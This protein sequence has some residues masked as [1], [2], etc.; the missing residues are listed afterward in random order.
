M[1]CLALPDLPAVSRHHGHA[2]NL[3]LP[4][5]SAAVSSASS[6]LVAPLRKPWSP[7]LDPAPAVHWPDT[8]QRP[9][10]KAATLSLLARIR[11]VRCDLHQDS[12]D[13]DIPSCLMSTSG[14][15]YVFL[16]GCGQLFH[17]F[18]DGKGEQVVSAPIRGA[19]SPRAPGRLAACLQPLLT[20]LMS[21]ALRDRSRRRPEALGGNV[22][23]A[24]PSPAEWCPLVIS[25]AADKL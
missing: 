13:V 22:C 21:L 8:I 4:E 19:G 25:S 24:S 17:A 12:F 6:V 1:P 20:L 3:H 5:R 2:L 15:S 14:K 7:K 9:V 11:V 18:G 10:Q 23:A 16:N